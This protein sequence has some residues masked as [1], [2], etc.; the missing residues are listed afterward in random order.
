MRTALLSPEQRAER[1]RGL[2]DMI[3]RDFRWTAIPS[4]LYL[5]AAEIPQVVSDASDCIASLVDRVPIDRLG[6]LERQVRSSTLRAYS[7]HELTVGMVARHEWPLQMWKLFTFHRSGL[8][9]EAALRK[10]LT[11]AAAEDRLPYLLLRANDWVR[12]IRVLAS[13]E[14]RLLLRADCLDAWTSSLGL[15]QS[16]RDRARAD[17]A[18]ISE[19]LAS[20]LLAAEERPRI[21]LLIR[22]SPR[23]VARWTLEIAGRLP[24][25]ERVPLLTNS[26]RHHDPTIRL[27]AT[28]QLLSVSDHPDRRAI[29]S[30][31]A[32][33]PF[34]PVRREALYG[35]LDAPSPARES[36]LHAALLDRHISIR[37]AA[38]TY[39][40]DH[41]AASGVVFD[42]RAAYL[43]AIREHA[44][45]PS[46]SMI[47]GLGE[48]GVREDVAVIRGYLSSSVPGLAAAAL[49]AATN[50]DPEGIQDWCQT[51]I[52]DPRPAVSSVAVRFL[53]ARRCASD[54]ESLRAIML[55]SPH[56]HARRGALRLLLRRNQYEAIID[57]I[58]SLQDVD[59][60]IVQVASDYIDS[61]YARPAP[62]GPTPAQAAEAA[63][64]LRKASSRLS[65]T[66][67]DAVR[68]R[69]GIATR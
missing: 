14:L 25:S 16:T 66:R 52:S 60:R 32:Q 27:H 1:V 69:F 63:K 43:D 18:W 46:R 42:P 30:R 44:P 65:A 58:D 59:P 53:A 22:S 39:L 68:A 17:H 51:L 5:L 45:S 9:R 33:D 48:C 31:A 26:L 54:R 56:A 20:L 47:L 50:L 37:H 40:R 11:Y 23:P 2:L 15:V 38:R 3:R 4:L 41:A 64:S 12:P 67:A 24:M 19:T 57:A 21:E 28:R 29:I 62:Q 49:R 35:I 7:W 6:Q 13:T 55:Q 34:M 61:A 10:L 36:H 8:L